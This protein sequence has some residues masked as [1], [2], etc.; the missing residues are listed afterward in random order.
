[1]THA[2]R[3]STD[4]GTFARLLAIT[5]LL[6]VGAGAA[7]AAETAVSQ[8]GKKFSTDRARLHIGDVLVVHNE[9]TVT[10]NLQVNHPL[11]TYNSGAQ[12][13]GQ[14]VRIAFPGAGNYLVYCGIHPKMKL[15]VA[16]E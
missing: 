13:P 12:E 16:V 10:H 9:D 1:M 6:A 4:A 3:R 7:W 2:T 8:H 11:L 5:A 15:R 14:T